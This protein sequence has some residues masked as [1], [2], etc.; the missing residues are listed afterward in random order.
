MAVQNYW[1]NQNYAR[2]NSSRR[3]TP[4]CSSRTTSSRPRLRRRPRAAGRPRRRSGA[5]AQ[6]GAGRLR[7]GPRAAGAQGAQASSGGGAPARLGWRRPGRLRA[8]GGSGGRG[9]PSRTGR[10]CGPLQPDGEAGISSTWAAPRRGRRWTATCS[11]A[12]P[13][14]C[15]PT[16]SRFS[17]QEAAAYQAAQLA[18]RAEGP[19]SE[20][21]A[22]AYGL[23]GVAAIRAAGRGRS[24]GPAGAPRNSNTDGYPMPRITQTPQAGAMPGWDTSKWSDPNHQTPKYVVGRIL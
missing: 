12:R 15:R 17:L 11:T 4:G 21:V 8:A 6:Q 14:A 1:G 18:G 24:A 16:S 19:A 5:S 20:L 9:A 22:G 10:R 7:A 23:P 3:S 2:G 13:A